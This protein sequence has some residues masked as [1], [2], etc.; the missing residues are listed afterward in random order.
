[1]EYSFSVSMKKKVYEG[2]KNLQNMVH[3]SMEK[4]CFKNKNR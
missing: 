3:K 1:M 4:K 2:L